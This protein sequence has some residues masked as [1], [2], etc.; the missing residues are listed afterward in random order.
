VVQDVPSPFG[1]LATRAVIDG[2]QRLTTLQLLLAALHG[3]LARR[4]WPTLAGQV[5]ALVANPQEFCRSDDDRYKVWPTVKDRPAFN[6]LFN[7][8]T[9]PDPTKARGASTLVAAYIYFSEAIGEW[10]DRSDDPEA[11]AGVLVP[12]ITSCL[13]IAIIYLSASED[14]QEIFETLNARG[15]PLAAAELIKNFVFQ[16]YDGNDEDKEKAYYDYWRRFETPF[17]GDGDLDR[18]GQARAQFPVPAAVA[19]RAHA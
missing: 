13:K 16:Q 9:P 2:Q 4:G 5:S 11:R 6:Y 15:T 1:S 14:A 8:A 17:L 3:Q 18:A 10:L 12:A 7:P 19:D